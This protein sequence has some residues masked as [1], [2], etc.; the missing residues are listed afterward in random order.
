WRENAGFE[1]VSIRSDIRLGGGGNISCTRDRGDVPPPHDRPATPSHDVTAGYFRTWGIAI[2]AGRE[3]DEHDDANNRKVIVISKTG[4][5]KLF[6]TENPIG[7]T[8]LITGN[9]IRAEIVGI[10]GDIRSRQLREPNDMEL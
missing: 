8:L 9:S 7:Q 6:G 10:A 3:I 1:T 4:A 2:L 5:K